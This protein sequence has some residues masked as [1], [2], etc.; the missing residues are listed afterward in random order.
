MTTFDEL[1]AIDCGVLDDAADLG[2]A[3]GHRL[4]VIGVLQVGADQSQ[5][6]AVGQAELEPRGAAALAPTRRW[7]LDDLG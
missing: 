3:D 6:P 4:L 7:Q 2:H 5:R 1:V